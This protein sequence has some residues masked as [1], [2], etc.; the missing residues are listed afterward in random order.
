MKT[1]LFTPSELN[2]RVFPVIERINCDHRLSILEILPCR[3][4]ADHAP[5][6]MVPSM[7]QSAPGHD[8]MRIDFR[9]HHYCAKHVGELRLDDLLTDRLKAMIEQ[10]AKRKRPIDFKCNFDA[11]HLVYVSIFTP[12]YKYFE[13]I[14]H[15]MPRE[16]AAEHCGAIIGG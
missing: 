13:L 8:H 1:P 5:R 10:Q 4:P 2:R 15:L 14:K 16:Q 12:A 6:L 9:D 11:A 3:H 7:T